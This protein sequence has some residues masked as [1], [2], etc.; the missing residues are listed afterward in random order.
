MKSFT[1]FV[2]G[3]FLVAFGAAGIWL[4]FEQH[5]GGIGTFGVFQMLLGFT[6]AYISIEDL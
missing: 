3:A 5:R 2:A 6:V 4:G 1:V